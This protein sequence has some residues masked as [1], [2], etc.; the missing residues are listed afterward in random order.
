MIKNCKI[1]LIETDK[2][3]IIGRFKD[4]MT[5]VL[6]TNDDI[7]RGVFVDIIITSGDE[8]L[9]GDLYLDDSNSIRTSVT[10]DKDYWSRRPDYVKIISSSNPSHNVEQLDEDWIKSFITDFNNEIYW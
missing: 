1:H 5:L 4:T 9:E 2:F 3:S 10:S 8:I 7:P 6:N